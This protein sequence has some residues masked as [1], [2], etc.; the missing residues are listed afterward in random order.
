MKKQ[1]CILVNTVY[2]L[3]VAVTIHETLLKNCETDL[4]VSD[5]TPILK[6]I[7]ESGRFSNVFRNCY[8][9]DSS[10]LTPTYRNNGLVNLFE[11]L[12]YNKNTR[13]MLGSDLKYYDEVYYANCDEIMKELFKSAVRKNPN[14]LFQSF[15][16]GMFS[17]VKD[18]G[19][20]I[21]SKLGAFIFR[22]L[23]RYDD[24]R[25]NTDLYLFEPKLASS[26]IT[27]QCKRI[28]KPEKPVFQILTDLFQFTPQKIKEPFIFFGQG[29]AA[30]KQEK[31]YRK[32][33]ETAYQTIGKEDFILKKHPRKAPLDEFGDE[34]KVLRSNCPW[35]LF[36]MDHNCDD[37]ILI[38]IFSTS[39]V[40]GK[41]LFESKTTTILMPEMANDMFDIPVAMEEYTKCFKKIAAQYENVYLVASKEELIE[42]LEKRKKDCKH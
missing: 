42:L 36:E 13:T 10:K 21:S 30:I 28:P 3:I 26:D 23:L 38:S 1:I 5:K 40:T 29:A 7:Y 18:P 15:E 4:I 9:A 2:Q 33:I 27:K 35:E 20:L 31:E 8:F 25:Q 34:M 11:S 24:T 17:Y 39:C 19:V 12:F 14:V 22:Y 41:L 6:K 16:D 37:N 32:I